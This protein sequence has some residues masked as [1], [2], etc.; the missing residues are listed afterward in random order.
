MP[1]PL[2]P[3]FA[4]SGLKALHVQIPHVKALKASGLEALH[5]KNPHANALEAIH[6][7]PE[8]SKPF[9]PRSL[10]DATSGLKSF[11]HS[12]AGGLQALRVKI[13]NV[14]ALEA[15]HLPQGLN[16]SHAKAVRVITACIGEYKEC[17]P[18]SETTRRS[19]S[20]F[21]PNE[22]PC[23]AQRFLCSYQDFVA[24][25]ASVEC[26]PSCQRP[27]R[28]FIRRRW[29]PSPSRSNFYL[30]LPHE[31]LFARFAKKALLVCP[32]L[33]LT[34]FGNSF[35]LTICTSVRLRWSSLEEQV[36]DLNFLS[37]FW[38]SVIAQIPDVQVVQSLG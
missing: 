31:V 35:E 5:V 3:S 25:H 14:K 26:A 10:D 12:F 13:P 34:R 15:I 33:C 18:P 28:P 29:A 22:L 30:A 38:F 6:S 11:G 27:L 19:T 32:C 2:K 17:G 1:R 21:Q 9:T 8:S 16:I 23:H 24:R 7:R 36:S 4:T 37:L 20:Q